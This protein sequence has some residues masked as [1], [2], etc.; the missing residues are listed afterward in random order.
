MP[1]VPRR[2]V[3]AALAVLLLASSPVPKTAGAAV[4]YF[5][6]PAVSTS[7]NDGN[8]AGLIVPFLISTPEGELRYLVAPLL[9]HNS[10]VGVKGAMN[11]FAYGTRGQ[12]VKFIASAAEEIERRLTLR[13]TD[14]AFGQGRFSLGFEGG[15]VKNATSRFFGFSQNSLESEETN[16]TNREIRAHW[17]LGVRL[18]DVTQIGVAQR[19]RDLTVLRGATDLPFTL[20]VFPG[21]DGGDGA[22]ILGNRAFFLYDTRDNLVS[23]TDG[24]TFTAYAEANWNFDNQDDSPYYRYEFDIKK[25]FPSP[26]KR[27]ILVA[28]A[29][30]QATFGDRVPFYERSALGGQNNLRGYGESR[31]VDKQLLA[32]SAEQRLHV[33]R[34]HIFNVFADFEVAPFVDIGRVF[35]TFD[36]LQLFDSFEVTPGIGFRGIVRPNVVG[37]VDVGVSREGTAVFAGLDYPF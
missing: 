14:P 36:D 17:Y 9:I 16:Y 34:A 8:E 3:L 21:V 24:M 1:S 31:F 20:A 23:P 11:I 37:R 30:L 22:R 32:F 29:N 6:I 7:K 2:A 10:I 35:N 28:R 18:D 25:L 27:A 15:F 12:S 13:Y 33:L 26:S 5:P 4:E 19:Y